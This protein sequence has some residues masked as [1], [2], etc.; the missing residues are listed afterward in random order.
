MGNTFPLHYALLTV[1]C[2]AQ[3]RAFTELRIP[4]S[5]F[6]LFLMKLLCLNTVAESEKSSNELIQLLLLRFNLLPPKW[7]RFGGLQIT[8]S[9]LFGQQVTITIEKYL[10]EWSSC[11]TTFPGTCQGA[12]KAENATLLG[13]HTWLTIERTQPTE[14]RLHLCKAPSQSKASLAGVCWNT[15]TALRSDIKTLKT[16]G[17]I[18]PCT[19]CKVTTVFS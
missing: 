17:T 9:E 7:C 8:N 14:M 6:Y 5:D 1:T 15:H 2:Q 18:W 4:V 13:L 11:N 16:A 19:G 3:L 12:S 10:E